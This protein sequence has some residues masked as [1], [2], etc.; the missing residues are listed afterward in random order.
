MQKVTQSIGTGVSNRSQSKYT[1]LSNTEKADNNQNSRLQLPQPPLTSELRGQRSEVGLPADDEN[2]SVNSSDSALHESVEFGYNK[3]N[4]LSKIITQ[5]ESDE[6]LAKDS[7]SES[8]E[9]IAKN[10]QFEVYSPVSSSNQIQLEIQDT[11]S[12]SNSFYDSS[13]ESTLSDT[14]VS[15]NSDAQANQTQSS[16][17][18]ERPSISESDES[19]SS[20]IDVS[21]NNNI[22][23]NQT[24]QSSNNSVDSSDS[25]LHESVAFGDNKDN[26]LAKKITQFESDEK[27]AK[28]S[29]SE[30]D[31]EIA[32]NLQ[33]EEYSPVSSSQ[34]SHL[35]IQVLTSPSNRSSTS[36]SD[37][38][39]AR[40]I[41][42]EYELIEADDI[43]FEECIVPSDGSCFSTSLILLTH[44]IGH[45]LNKNQLMHMLKNSLDSMNDIEMINFGTPLNLPNPSAAEIKASIIEAFEND[46][47]L[48]STPAGELYANLIQ[49]EMDTWFKN[50]NISLYRI[51]KNGFKNHIQ[52]I[53]G[54]P[55]VN[56]LNPNSCVFLTYNGSHYNYATLI[57]NISPLVDK[58]KATFHASNSRIDVT[59]LT[60]TEIKQIVID[61]FKQLS[62]IKDIPMCVIMGIT[63]RG[64]T[65]LINYL[66][67]ILQ[68]D[69]DRGFVGSH[70]GPSV[71]SS[72]N[73]SET[74]IP[75]LTTLE[76]KTK[77]SFVVIRVVLVK[78]ETKMV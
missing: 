55:P 44:H 35:G 32:K 46:T 71:S 43:V 53:H 31:E 49:R 20:D 48:W 27:L 14:D 68:Y 73:T 29:Q 51:N 12:P 23:S 28:E 69:L 21:K 74:F 61:Y 34:Q 77:A 4:S 10:L 5:F 52:D 75:N 7:Q 65:T 25:A 57:R 40:D 63:G 3:D 39:I 13:D 41:H 64:K 22:Q 59:K 11:S 33:N 16:S 8:D 56:D 76:S 67:N 17:S 24:Q 58:I 1:N 50:R 9:E 66:A 78:H 26:S 19:I 60:K 30:S 62:L 18:N 70:N 6:K 15:G 72:N 36:K 47:R 38:K 54:S 45:P 37:E 2:N 42:I